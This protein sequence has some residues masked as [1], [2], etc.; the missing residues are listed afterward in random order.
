MPDSNNASIP[1]APK[2]SNPAEHR[3][4]LFVAGR[5]RRGAIGAKIVLPMKNVCAALIICV[6]ALAQT[7][8]TAPPVPAARKTTAKTGLP[9]ATAAKKTLPVRP[10]L[11]EPSTLRAKAPEMF[12]ARLITSKG[13]VVIEVTRAWS[14]NGA[15]RFYNLVR[16]GFFTDLYF[17]RVV[18]GFMAQFG[19]SSKPEITQKWATATIVDDPVVQSNTRGMV[20]FAKS[21]APNSRSTQFFIN[22]GDNRNL[23]GMGFSPF[24][25]VIEGMDVVDNLYSGYGEQANNQQAITAQGKAFLD[26]NFPKLD[27]IVTAAIVPPVPA[28]GASGAPR[29]RP[30]VRAATKA[31]TPAAKK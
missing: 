7:K 27:K 31:T 13:P 4:L 28:V 18:A 24:G 19:M 25:K 9:A 17:F 2:H 6:A 10:N 29:P 30:V 12:R 16:A 8:S 23:D 14:P 5:R 1:D 20:T 11:L 26:A 3:L 22:Y 21:G 15:D